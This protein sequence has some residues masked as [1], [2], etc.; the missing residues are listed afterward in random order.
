MKIL[1]FSDL[2]LEFGVF[3]LPKIEADIVVLAGDI[4][5]GLK[6]LEW[7]KK[8]FPNKTVLYILGNHE[9]Y[10]YA[11]PKLTNKLRE[12]ALGSQVH[13]LENDK[14]EID[15]FKFL[16]STLWTDFKLFGEAN[17]ARQEAQWAM[18]DYYKI[19]VDPHF[20]KL[21]AID[22]QVLHSKSIS[23]L[24]S[25]FDENPQK[26]IVI[27][28]HAPSYQSLPK[29]KNSNL[30]L[31]NAAY[32]SSLDEFIINNRPI[33]WIHGHIHESQDYKIG[34]TRVVSN[35][36]GYAFEE[37]PSFRREFIVEV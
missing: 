29:T 26:T 33:L 18:N 21:R 24:K 8:S 1:I 36:R 22:T 35:P 16:G 13:I 11:I 30:D 17:I 2:H 25:E 37:S 4:H 9:Y 14:F 7:A 20:R 15:G 28:H 34:N 10:G 3:E 23:W 27:T 32:A 12:K 31:L 5:P 6:G 19:R